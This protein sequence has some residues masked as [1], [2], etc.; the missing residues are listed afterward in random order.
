MTRWSVESGLE[1]KA[2][3]EA[4][5]KEIEYR[6]QAQL[7]LFTVNISAVGLLGGFY[8]SGLNSPLFL[9]LIGVISPSI[10]LQ[11]LDHAFTI[12]RL[13]DYCRRLGYDWESKV[14]KE[15]MNV[16]RRTLFLAQVAIAFGVSGF[17]SVVLLTEHPDYRKGDAWV[18]GSIAAGIMTAFFVI[19]WLVYWWYPR[20]QEKKTMTAP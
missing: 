17:V 2:K 11:W 13:G 18:A 5:R 8:T 15:R 4:A 19:E 10:G 16:L 7:A 1:D 9:L 3:F 14:A 12:D 20:S 6:T